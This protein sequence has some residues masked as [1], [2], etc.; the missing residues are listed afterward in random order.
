[1]TA[2]HK[3]RA[4]EEAHGLLI[5]LSEVRGSGVRSIP[6]GGWPKWGK[7]LFH[8]RSPTVFFNPQLLRVDAALRLYARIVENQYGPVVGG[9]LVRPNAEMQVPGSLSAVPF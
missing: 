3:P 4:I 7:G 6:S 1:V 8:G 5:E 9:Q 2:R